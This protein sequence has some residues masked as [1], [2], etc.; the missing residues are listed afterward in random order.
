MH[1]GPQFG[2]VLPKRGMS[3][4][5]DSPSSKWGFPIRSF[6]FFAL[7][8]S[9]ATIWAAV[10]ASRKQWR[11]SRRGG[12]LSQVRYASNSNRNFTLRLMYGLV[13]DS[14]TITLY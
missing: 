2:F 1:I 10:L 4:S 11:I 5:E 13:S 9:G 6:V 3:I 14:L 12:V 8:L 7:G